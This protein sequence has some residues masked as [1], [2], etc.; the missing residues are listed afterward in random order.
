M[1]GERERERE[2][3]KERESETEGGRER[4]RER[5]FSNLKIC[6]SGVFDMLFSESSQLTLARLLIKAGSHTAYFTRWGR[7]Q[8]WEAGRQF[9]CKER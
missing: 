7:R 8:L 4:E 9:R 3:Q 5:D 2:R 1:E 6:F